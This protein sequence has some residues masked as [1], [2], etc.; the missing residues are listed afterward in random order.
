MARRSA[1]VVLAFGVNHLGALFA[2][3]LRLVCDGTDHRLGKIDGFH[4]NLGNLDA[5]G[6]VSRS[7]TV[8]RRR[9]IFSRSAQQVVESDFAQHTA[10]RGLAGCDVA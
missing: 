8:C 10:Q 2:L 5:P 4:F 7:R 9:L 1:S 3:G 6:A